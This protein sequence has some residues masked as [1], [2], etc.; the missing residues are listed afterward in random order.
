MKE[1]IKIILK[2][3]KKNYRNSKTFTNSTQG[4]LFWVNNKQQGERLKNEANRSALKDEYSKNK[5]TA[6]FN[7]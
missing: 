6:L 3:G 1:I 4:C 7:R 5:L 2:N